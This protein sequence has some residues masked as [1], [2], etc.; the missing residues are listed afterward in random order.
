MLSS[1]LQWHKGGFLCAFASVLTVVLPTPAFSEESKDTDAKW[2]LE[3]A[4]IAE[5][6]TVNWTI[7]MTTGHLASDP[8]FGAETR[9]VVAGLMMQVAAEG[10]SFEIVGAELEPWMH[11]KNGDWDSLV[12][13]LPIAP[14]PNSQ[15]GS[16]I[17]QVAELLA[18]DVTG[19]LLIFSS[20]PSQL[21]VGAKG[22]KVRGGEGIIEGL[23]GPF[24]RGVALPDYQGERE[25]LLTLYVDPAPI[26]GNSQRAPM[27]GT[28][29]LLDAGYS[30]DDS[31]TGASASTS[32]QADSTWATWLILATL[33]VSLASLVAIIV[34]ATR[35]NDQPKPA[36]DDQPIGSGQSEPEAVVGSFV[37]HAKKL[38]IMIDELYESAD[39]IK[40][41][42][43]T[44]EADLRS[45]V[46][47]RDKQMARWADSACDLA[48]AIDSLINNEASKEAQ[49]SLQR[50]CQ[51]HMNY[52]QQAG[53]DLIRPTSGDSID[54]RIHEA[55]SDAGQ[56]CS[57][58][59]GTV[60]EIIQCGIRIGTK[61]FRRAKVGV[62]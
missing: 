45:E 4:K 56:P 13:G 36:N 21:P 57:G 8:A 28:G 58:A 27:Q 3:T 33:T 18:P 7:V 17:E 38:E 35:R 40:Q 11:R 20:G 24:R 1:R 15:G 54:P 41:L 52:L 46:L 10:D 42:R 39:Q 55:I 22:T 12:L 30:P 43:D 6:G 19:V 26:Q 25:L 49:M 51:Y 16:D 23:N 60:D 14:K 59:P 29:S 62:R 37:Q 34:L 61:V 53:V 50:V 32:R 31:E 44:S 48:N 2:L 9:K 47:S 5:V